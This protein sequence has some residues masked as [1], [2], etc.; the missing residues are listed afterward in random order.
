[1]AITSLL[2]G[3]KRWQFVFQRL[4]KVALVGLNYNRASN[5][6][7]NGERWLVEKI[8]QWGKGRSLVVMDV[9]ANVGNYSAALLEYLADQPLQLFCFEPAAATFAVLQTKMAGR[10]QVKLFQLGMSAQPGTT[11]L[12]SKAGASGLSSVYQRDLSH[13]QTALNEEEIIQLDSLDHFCATH[14][15]EEIDVLKMDVEGHEVAVLQGASRMLHE[16]QVKIIQFEFGGCNID[17]RTYFRD[18][19]HLLNSNFK[20]FRLLADGLQPIERYNE[21][22]EVFQSANYVALRRDLSLRDFE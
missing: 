17:S 4:Y 15:I 8:A 22:L 19:F 2:W 9:G 16:K 6:Q 1:M 10:P 11:K 18:F 14:G 3:R 5:Y 7:G 20:I 12:F 13:R 21:A